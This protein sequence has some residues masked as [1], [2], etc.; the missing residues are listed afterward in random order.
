[1]H[2][3]NYKSRMEIHFMKTRQ[4]FVLLPVVAILLGLSHRAVSQSLIDAPDP[5]PA[6][7]ITASPLPDMKYTPPTGRTKANNYLFEAFGPYPAAG[8]AFSAGISQFTNSPP[9]W[10]QGM[11]GYSK[12][13]GS[14][15][16]MAA[17]EATTRYALATA[18]REDTMYY[19]C[20]CNRFLPRTRHAVLSTFTARHGLDGHREFSVSSLLAPYAASTVG[21]YGWYPGRFGAKDAFRMGNY[22][23]LTYMGG[24]VALEFLYGGPRSLLARMHLNNPHGSPDRG[25]D[26]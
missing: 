12:R 15:F 26:H 6:T 9:E 5:A 7:V 2:S 16:G 22:S 19:R 20:E 25:N 3:L 11:E 24:N 1:M 23:L 8:A 17:T 4:M 13:F 18:F 21:V 10:N 14:Y